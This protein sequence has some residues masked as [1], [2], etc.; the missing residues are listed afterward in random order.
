MS[1]QPEIP[2]EKLVDALRLLNTQEYSYMQA[3][4][5]FAALAEMLTFLRQRDILSKSPIDLENPKPYELAIT[6]TSDGQHYQITLQRPS[7]MN[8]KTTWCSTAAFS[9]ERGVIF[10]GQAISCNAAPVLRLVGVKHHGF[11]PTLDETMMNEEEEYVNKLGD[12][13][14]VETAFDQNKVENMVKALE[15]FWKNRGIAVEVRVRV[16]NLTEVPNGSRYA[17]LEFDVY[18]Q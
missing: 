1:G 18:K 3:N 9:D 5:R 12:R 11:D 14:R 6:T 17:V 2:K 13:P 4:Q 10:L 15:Q 8:D 16:N 7:D